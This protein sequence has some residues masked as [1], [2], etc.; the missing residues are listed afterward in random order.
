MDAVLVRYVDYFE[1]FL[2]V[3]EYSFSNSCQRIQANLLPYL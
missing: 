3:A 2:S 1:R